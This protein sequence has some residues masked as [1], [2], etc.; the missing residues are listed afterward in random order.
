[1]RDLLGIL[2]CVGRELY[3]RYGAPY[4]DEKL[5]PVAEGGNGDIMD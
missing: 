5:K 2:S 4:E 3:R 1:M